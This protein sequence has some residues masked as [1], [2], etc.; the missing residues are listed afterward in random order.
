MNER[1]VVIGATGLIGS[2]LLKLLLDDD[3]FVEV[4][5]LVRKWNGLAHAKLK[6][7]EIDFNDAN[8]ISN[9]TGTGDAVFCCIG[10]TKNKVK[11]DLDLYRKI[12][13]GIPA[14]TT[15]AA[16][17]K[18][19]RSYLLVSAVGADSAAGNFYLKIKGEAED[20]V[21]SLPFESTH[22][23]RPSFLTGPRKEKRPLEKILNPIIALL[24][25]LLSGSWRKYRS[26]QAIEVAQ[27]MITASLNRQKGNYIYYYDE[28][29]KLNN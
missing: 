18:G 27:A 21:R 7:F 15:K 29:K 3:R 9:A 28:M 25:P 24:S 19:Y 11:G 20:L 6:V 4:R 1:V 17:A 12:D 14:D 2:Q 22:I 10:T 23:F 26:I 5:I 8:Q 16:L 13:I